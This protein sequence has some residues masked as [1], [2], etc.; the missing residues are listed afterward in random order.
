MT[1]EEC[2]EYIKEYGYVFIVAKEGVRGE[3]YLATDR[4]TILRP[5]FVSILK[6]LKMPDA[7][8]EQIPGPADPSRKKW[9]LW[10]QLN[11]I[12]KIPQKLDF[13]EV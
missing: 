13:S 5:I 2:S 10:C 4:G 1:P 6:Y 9:N 12:P 8:D 7:R 3:L 11:L